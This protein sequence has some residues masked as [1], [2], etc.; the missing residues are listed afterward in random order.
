MTAT[1]ARPAG[2]RPAGGRR[3][4]ETLLAG[5]DRAGQR[6][7]APRRVV[8]E[9]ITDRAGPFTAADLVAAAGA[10]RLGIGRATIFRTL[11]LFATLELVERIDLP[12]GGH[13]YLACEPA[14]HHH[15]VCVRCGRATEVEDCGMSLVAAEIARRSGYR[16]AWHRLEMFGTCP[17]CLTVE[18]ARVPV[19]AS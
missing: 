2:G 14:H 3:T 4:A 11:D 10:R 6:R 1:V 8:A 13:A 15:V 7:T 19:G 12:D 9:L 16:V 17:S 5:L 18:A